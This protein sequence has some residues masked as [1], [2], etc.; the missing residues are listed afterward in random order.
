RRR[1][2][3]GTRRP[4]LGVSAHRPAA[5]LDVIAV[6]PSE[7]GLPLGV[8]VRAR[9]PGDVANYVREPVGSNLVIAR[10]AAIGTVCVLT[11]SASDLVIDLRCVARR[12]GLSGPRYIAAARRHTQ[13]HRHRRPVRCEVTLGRV[14]SPSRA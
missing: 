13:R 3:L 10:P 11:S 2:D 8:P 7:S 1:G 5:V 6:V 12:L 14:I 4:G 9:R